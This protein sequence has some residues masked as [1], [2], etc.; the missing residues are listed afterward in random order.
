VTDTW[1]GLDTFFDDDEVRVVDSA[2][3]VLAALRA[4]PATLDQFARRARLRTLEEHTGAHRAKQL[5][6]YFEE[7][8]TRSRVE[9]EAA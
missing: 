4:D 9:S 6:G 3:T 8:R 2:E 7:A 1:E 5:L